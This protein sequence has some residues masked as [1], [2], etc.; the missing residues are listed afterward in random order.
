MKKLKKT[1]VSLLLTL[2][3]VSGITP[4]SNLT[5]TQPIT[6]QAVVS[7]KQTAKFVRGVDG[8]TAKLSVAGK[9]YTFRFLAIDTPETVKLGTPVAFMGKRASDY[10]K[11][12][13]KKAKKIQIQYEKGNQTDKYGRKLAWIF[14]D[15]QLL[16]D[17]L[18]KKGYARVYYVYGNYKYTAK[19]R[20][21][22][23]VAKRKKLGVW[24]N[25]KAAFPDS[26]NSSNK[27]TT[28]KKT[29]KKVSTKKKSTKKSNTASSSYVW[30]PRT[31]SKYHSRSSCSNMKNPSKVKRP[32]AISRG[33]TPC[34]KCY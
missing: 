32:D 28:K 18:V 27:S 19:L 14:V 25:Y 5:G 9:T 29:T 24:K 4:V 23:K 34:S 10:T 17:K 11:S 13:L 3:M 8:D 15:G 2:V 21:S 12:E 1:I 22:E 6:V 16:Q 33:Y 20:A 26:K 31:G 30:I 7:K